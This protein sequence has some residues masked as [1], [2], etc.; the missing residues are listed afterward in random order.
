MWKSSRRMVFWA[1]AVAA[2]VV[3]SLAG[4]VGA[5]ARDGQGRDDGGQATEAQGHEQEQARHE[6]HGAN[7]A[8]AHAFLSASLAPSLPTDPAIHGV[9]AGGAP[10]ALDHGSVQV[11][12]DGHIRV[13]VEGLVIP[14]VH[15]TF[16]AGTARPVTV[17]S[18]SLYCAPDTS[19]AAATTQSVPISEHGDATISDTIHLPATCLAPI[20]LVHPNGNDGAYIA[21]TGWRG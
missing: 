3:L 21:V 11:Q 5:G 18:A 14:V 17:V 13:E 9:A 7:H 20:V 1:T 4:A 8:D 6:D 19:A 12:G 16:P 15:G 10:W 2:M